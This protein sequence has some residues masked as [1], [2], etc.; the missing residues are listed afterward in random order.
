MY[1]FN[2]KKQ[3]YFKQFNLALVR[4]LHVKTVLFR[5]IQFS[6]S[7]QFKCKNSKLLKPWLSSIWSI[8]WTLLGATTLGQSGP[9]SNGNKG[10]LSIPQSSSNTRTSPSDCLMSLSGHSLAGGGL[11]LLQRCSRCI[12]QPQLTG[13]IL[14]YN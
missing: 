3:F 14:H 8:N 11:T 4:S 13:A 6:I 9:G 7:M 2:V 1:S 5:V 10:V 12:L